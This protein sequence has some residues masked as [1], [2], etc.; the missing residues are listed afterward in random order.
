MVSKVF[1]SG[2]NGID[3]IRIEVEVDISHGL[4]SFSIVGLPEPSVKESRERVRAAI[5]TQASISPM[6]G[7]P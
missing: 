3:G 2:L 1:T 6:T 7:S 5:K 4:P